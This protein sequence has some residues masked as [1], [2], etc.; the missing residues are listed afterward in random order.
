MFYLL[1]NITISVAVAVAVVNVP[2]DQTLIFIWGR[3]NLLNVR[4]TMLLGRDS[5]V[6]GSGGGGGGKR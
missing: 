3:T 4:S 6:G 5:Y 1:I 2:S